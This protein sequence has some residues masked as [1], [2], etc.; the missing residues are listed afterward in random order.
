MAAVVE[1]PIKPERLRM[2]MNLALEQA[3]ATAR[4][5]ADPAAAT[6]SVA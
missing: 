4:A 6:R 3:A 2:A 1:K 5:E